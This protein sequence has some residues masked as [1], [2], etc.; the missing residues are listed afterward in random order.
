MNTKAC[1]KNRASMGSTL[2]AAWL[3]GAAMVLSGCSKDEASPTANADSGHEAS[4]APT[5]RIDIP[6][7]VRDNLGMTFVPVEVRRVAQTLRVPGRFELMPSATREYRTMLPGRV[8]LLADQFEEVAAGDVLYR[9]DSPAWRAM[10]TEISDAESQIVRLQAR[11]ETFEPL[12]AA[13]QDHRGMLERANQIRRERLAQLEGVA[14]AGGGRAGE[15]LDARALVAEGEAQLAEVVE[16]EQ[17]MLASRA[18]AAADHAAAI[19]RKGLLI[20]SA[21]SLLGETAESLLSVGDGGQPRWRSVRSITVRAEEPGVVVSIGLANGGWADQTAPVLTVVQSGRV[22]FRGSVLQSDIA[23][24]RDGL[25]ALIVAPS[26]TRVRGAVDLLDV[27]KGTVRIAP[28]AE[29]G[30]RTI[31]VLVVPD[32]VSAWARAGVTAQLEITIDQTA[33]PVLAIPKAA[34]HRDGLVPVYFRRDPADANKAIRVEADLGLD[35]GRWVVVNSG[36]RL[37]DE[38]VLD[39]SYQLMLA[40][41]TTGGASKSGHFHAD[42]TWHE[43]EH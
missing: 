43:G 7:A 23:A 2:T 41:A 14:G 24:I 30:Q 9:I 3:L 34:I 28:S 32:K 39:G 21:A 11:L 15:L 29:P 40:T 27:M 19:A 1:M 8:E 36:L 35:D 12:L 4:A 22:R 42:G 17:E 25:E 16:K 10:Q 33:R 26:P 20:E 18:E 37:G 6:R 38:V 5:N 13:H 31:D